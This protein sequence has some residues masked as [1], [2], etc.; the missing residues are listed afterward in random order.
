MSRTSKMID[1]RPIH[2]T[3]VAT[4]RQIIA[5]RGELAM[6]HLKV[7]R[8]LRD[9]CGPPGS[10]LLG[11]AL[12]L[13]GGAWTDTLRGRR[14]VRQALDVRIPGLELL[15]NMH[16]VL[17]GPLQLCRVQTRP[18]IGPDAVHNVALAR[19]T[20][21]AS[22]VGGERLERSLALPFHGR[23]VRVGLRVVLQRQVRPQMVHAGVPEHGHLLQGVINQPG[24]RAGL[25]KCECRHEALD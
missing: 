9:L 4:R 18:R 21:G 10:L 23:V 14:V 25:C 22:V 6:E 1:C 12:Q 16:V 13:R 19:G 5:K 8:N 17:V 3:S 24:E 2:V 20:V 11:K 15:C 7:R